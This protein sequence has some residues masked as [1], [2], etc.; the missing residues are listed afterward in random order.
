MLLVPWKN[1]VKKYNLLSNLI[2]NFDPAQN[3]E[4]IITYNSVVPSMVL[5]KLISIVSNMGDMLCEY[6]ISTAG[7]TEC[8]AGICLIS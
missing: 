3:I 1:V 5:Q 8:F 4:K 6:C 7:S 2:E